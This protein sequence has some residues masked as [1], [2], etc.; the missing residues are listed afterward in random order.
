MKSFSYCAKKKKKLCRHWF[1][2]KALEL[3]TAANRDSLFWVTGGPCL[4]WLRQVCGS[5]WCYLECIGVMI[6]IET[7]MID[8]VYMT[9]VTKSGSGMHEWVWLRCM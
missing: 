4:N 9:M 8:D 6:V 1:G 5:P 7:E 2:R 3:W